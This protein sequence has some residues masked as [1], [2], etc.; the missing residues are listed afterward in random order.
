MTSSHSLEAAPHSPDDQTA[1]PALP[2]LP[3]IK[4]QQ[5]ETGSMR[6][7]ST[8]PHAINNMNT[9]EQQQSDRFCDAGARPRKYS[10]QLQ[11]NNNQQRRITFEGTQHNPSNREP[12]TLFHCSKSLD[13]KSPINSPVVPRRLMQKEDNFILSNLPENGKSDGKR[14][15]NYLG[16]LLKISSC[17]TILSKK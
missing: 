1:E 3:D 12:H 9:Y 15:S 11:R 4:K 16:Q 17:G 6:W 7:S 13:Y 14:D 5:G 8:L 10:S 2:Y